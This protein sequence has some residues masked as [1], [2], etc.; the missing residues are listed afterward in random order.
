[1]DS[2]TEK[3]WI[4]LAHLG[5][6][7]GYI[8]PFGNVIVPLVVYSMKK[9]AP[10]VLLH[11][12]NSLNFQISITLYILVSSILIF[13]LIGIGLIFLLVVLQFI[14]VILAAVKADKGEIFNYPLT[15]NFIKD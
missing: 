10:L 5:T 6:F 13:V 12:R 7:I 11:S 15:I 2:L 4:L 9:D 14:L 3:Q 1:M 8:F